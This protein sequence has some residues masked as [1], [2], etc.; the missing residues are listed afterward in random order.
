MFAD[1]LI[2]LNA[3]I[4]DGLLHLKALKSLFVKA[5]QYDHQLIVLTKH[6]Q[7]LSAQKCRNLYRA[8]K[9]CLQHSVLDIRCS[10]F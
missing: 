6:C 9:F 4:A 7:H 5:Q 8:V 2:K 10:I 3:S 1:E